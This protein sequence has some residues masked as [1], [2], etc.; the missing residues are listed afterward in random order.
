[1]KPRFLDQSSFNIP[2][3]PFQ[4]REAAKAAEAAD[5]GL[6]TI[7]FVDANRGSLSTAGTERV[8][9]SALAPVTGDMAGE[10]LGDS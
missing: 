6:N 7:N 1:M 2:H 9:A 8:L 3:C 10:W 4:A 5:K